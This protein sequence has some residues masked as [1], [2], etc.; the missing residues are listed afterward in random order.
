[1]VKLAIIE[2]D[3]IIKESLEN[4]LGSNEKISL[5]FISGSVED[6]L[7]TLDVNTEN[8]IDCILLDVGLPGMSGLEG[9]KHIKAKLPNVNIIMLTTS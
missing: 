2:D 3:L 8:S 4:F 7:I 1:M 9:I 6:F 5:K